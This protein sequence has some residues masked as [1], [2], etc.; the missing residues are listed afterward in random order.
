MVKSKKYS[1]KRRLVLRE[2]VTTIGANPFFK[3]FM[4]RNISCSAELSMIF[5]ITSGPVLRS[6]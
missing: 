6:V 4:S 3:T 2:K 5:F 1:L